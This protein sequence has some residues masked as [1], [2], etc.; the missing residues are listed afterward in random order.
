MQGNLSGINFRV[1]SI[2]HVALVAGLLLFLAMI[3]L[4]QLNNFGEIL[5]GEIVVVFFFLVPFFALSTMV[6]S[7]II[8][9][10]RIDSVK[11]SMK[12]IEA[13]KDAYFSILLMRWAMIEGPG[14]FSCVVF[15]LT[16]NYIFLGMAL[17]LT[18]FLIMQ[19]PSIQKATDELDLNPEEVYFLR[20]L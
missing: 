10:K 11:D 4:L 20:N 17:V 19:Y 14:F 15:L 18:G 16:S 5:Q 8:T 1:L 2:I 12:T 3:L 7:K 9:N 6:F 13:K